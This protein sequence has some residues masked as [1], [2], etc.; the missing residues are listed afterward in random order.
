MGKDT[1]KSKYKGWGSLNTLKKHGFVD[2]IEQ[3]GEVR[4]GMT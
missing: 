4:Y 2:T 3:T 1:K